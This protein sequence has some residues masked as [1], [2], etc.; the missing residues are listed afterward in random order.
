[1]MPGSSSDAIAHSRPPWSI[2]LMMISLAK[3]SSFCWISP[4][5]FASLVAPR[6]SARPARRTLLAIILAAS[7]RSYRMPD[8]SPVASGCR[9]S[10]SMMNRSIVTTDVAVC[11][12]TGRPLH[13]G[14]DAC[15]LGSRRTG[16]RPPRTGSAR[17]RAAG[18]ARR[19]GAETHGLLQTGGRAGARARA[20]P[21]RAARSARARS[22]AER[23]RRRP[24]RG[25]DTT[26]RRAPA[27]RRAAS[28]RSRARDSAR[29][30][31]AAA[32]SACRRARRQRRDARDGARAMRVSGSAL[33]DRPSFVARLH[34]EC[35]GRRCGRRSCPARS[36]RSTCAPDACS[37]CIT[38]ASGWPYVLCAP[39]LTSASRGRTAARKRARR[40]RARCRDARP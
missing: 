18:S 34:L 19:S 36:V 3:T 1:M 31:Q 2:A 24:S 30:A 8:S 20:I 40:A 6:M 28:A 13:G 39:T 17:S 15:R 22:C 23:D 25:R 14:R 10:C 29:A 32:S 9:R 27:V 21:A 38:S 35:V 11:W 12:T 7:A 5:T 37:A 16:A 26:R 33:R 4:C